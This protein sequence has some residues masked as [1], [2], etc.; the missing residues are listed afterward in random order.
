MNPTYALP[1]DLIK[2]KMKEKKKHRIFEIKISEFHFYLFISL[3]NK[4]YLI[5]CVILALLMHIMCNFFLIKVWYVPCLVG[6]FHLSFLAMAREV[7]M[8]RHQQV[9]LTVAL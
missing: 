1:F 7:I 2:G 5:F 6:S 8:A 4:V 3:P 9:S